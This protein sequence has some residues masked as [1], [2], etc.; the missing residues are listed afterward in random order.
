MALL[1]IAPI[2]RIAM[3]IKEIGETV[4]YADLAGVTDSVTVRHARKRH[5]VRGD[6]PCHTIIFV[7]D[8]AVP[9][10]TGL[11]AFE[12]L[13][14]AI[15]DIQSDIDV[16]SDDETG[17]VMLGRFNAALV[18]ALR[19]DLLGLIDDVI[20]GD[21]D[22]ED[23]GQAEDGRLVRSLKVRYRVS[24]ENGNVLFT[25]EENG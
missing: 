10:E 2:N 24:S 16:P 21:I 20:E 13:R 15:F 18:Q 22:P 9:G 5:P 4:D 7:G 3:R 17:L 23:Q 14:E 8:E 19:P 25:A 11:N 1:P 12:I 6:R